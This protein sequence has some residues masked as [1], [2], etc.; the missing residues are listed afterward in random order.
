MLDLG[1]FV[2]SKFIIRDR[3]VASGDSLAS[4]LYRLIFSRLMNLSIAASCGHR[5]L[6]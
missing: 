3:S 6:K 4:L 5:A 2:A 1:H